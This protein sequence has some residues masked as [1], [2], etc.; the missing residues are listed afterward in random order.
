MQKSEVARRDL[1]IQL[2]M[3]RKAEPANRKAEPANE[4]PFQLFEK[5]FQLLKSRHGF[6]R[7]KFSPFAMFHK[8]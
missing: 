1:A 7:T 8:L 6:L 4:K 2:P 3:Y 5:P